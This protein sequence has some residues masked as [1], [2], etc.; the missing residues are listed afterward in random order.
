MPDDLRPDDIPDFWRLQPFI[1]SPFIL[2]VPLIRHKR[3]MQDGEIRSLNAL[4]K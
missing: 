1:A 4:M 3:H 2:A